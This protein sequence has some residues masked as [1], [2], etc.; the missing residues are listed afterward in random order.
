LL[1]PIKA[2]DLVFLGV[3]IWNKDNSIEEIPL[4]P[5]WVCLFY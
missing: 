5:L 2:P 4:T 1:K 3:N